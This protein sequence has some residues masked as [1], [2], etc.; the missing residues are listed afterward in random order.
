MTDVESSRRTAAVKRRAL[1][2]GFNAVGI[3]TL[4]PSAYSDAFAE[5][6]ASGYHGETTALTPQGEPRDERRPAVGWLHITECSREAGR[7]CSSACIF[8]TYDAR[9]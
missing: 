3:T 9:Q 5:G 6:L 1:E 4:E 8:T 2:L 7:V